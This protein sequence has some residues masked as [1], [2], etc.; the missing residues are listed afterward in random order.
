MDFHLKYMYGD[1]G[2]RT[3]VQRYCHLGFYEHSWYT[4]FRY[5]LGLPTGFLVAN[6]IRFN[7]SSSGGGQIVYPASLRPYSSTRA[8]PD[9]TL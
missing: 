7:Y 9:R 2:N 4:I 8:I 3:H 5:Q 6:L 1:G